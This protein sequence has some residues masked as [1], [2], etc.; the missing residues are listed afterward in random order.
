MYFVVSRPTPAGESFSVV[1][2]TIP[3]MATVAAIVMDG[4]ILWSW[5]PA[6]IVEILSNH[7]E[8]ADTVRNLKVWIDVNGLVVDPDSGNPIH[9]DRIDQRLNP[10]RPIRQIRVSNEAT[11]TGY[12]VHKVVSAEWCGV[13]CY[14]V[15]S[16]DTGA[17]NG[18]STV[19]SVS[20]RDGNRTRTVS[21][22]EPKWIH[23]ELLSKASELIVYNRASWV[24][25]HGIPVSKGEYLKPKGPLN[26]YLL[27]TLTTTTSDTDVLREI[28]ARLR[29]PEY[30]PREKQGQVPVTVKLI[31]DPTPLTDP[32]K[33]R[34]TIDA[35]QNQLARIVSEVANKPD[36]REFKSVIYVSTSKQA[37]DIV[38]CLV[39][40]GIRAVAV[41]SSMTPE[42]RWY[43]SGSDDYDVIVATFTRVQIP[44]LKYVYNL[45]PAIPGDSVIQLAAK[46]LRDNDDVPDRRVITDFVFRG[47][48][49]FRHAART[50]I[51]AYT[52]RGFD[53]MYPSHLRGDGPASEKL[54]RAVWDL[55]DSQLQFERP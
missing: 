44:R 5:N 13:R 16:A 4:S 10:Y 15:I 8:F 9:K 49:A 48:S 47:R 46:A 17:T 18:F 42:D 33:S 24:D 28:G 32:D 55:L 34:A 37:T 45:R 14:R 25:E 21:I 39:A 23:G 11:D 51:K 7:R 41:L 2:D 22:T 40:S 38:A 35:T 54:R 19:E 1:K 26:S 3:L 12:I 30:N 52:D 27:R 20:V 43:L 36:N 50:R 6:T 53:V 29:Y 31:D